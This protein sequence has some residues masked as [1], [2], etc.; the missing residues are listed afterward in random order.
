MKAK[1]V[2]CCYRYFCTREDA[3]A[4]RAFVRVSGSAPGS[5][6][7]NS[8]LLARTPLHLSLPAAS[9]PSISGSSQEVHV[10]DRAQHPFR[11]FGF[12]CEAQRLGAGVG[13]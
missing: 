2:P 11:T 12:G 8:C 4:A 6:Q 7:A 5:M 9:G 1:G 10:W 13:W 3:G